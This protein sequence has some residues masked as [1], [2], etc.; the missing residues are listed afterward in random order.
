MLFLCKLGH[1]QNVCF[2]KFPH[3]RPPWVV[4]EERRGLSSSQQVPSGENT[5]PLGE[6]RAN[7][8]NQTQLQHRIEFPPQNTRQN[9][10][11]Q[12]AVAAFESTYLCDIQRDSL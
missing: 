4:G 9:T 8:R 3:L 12:T 2:N 7:K 11:H 6:Q 10:S 5:R 1:T